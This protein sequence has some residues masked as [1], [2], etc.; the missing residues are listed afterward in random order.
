ML[1]SKVCF[2]T[3]L[4]LSGVVSG[5][6]NSGS[7]SGGTSQTLTPAVSWPQPSSIPYGTALSATQ[8]NATANVS[9]TFVY[10]PVAGTVL[11][12]GTQG[13]TVTFTPA[14]GSPMTTTTLIRVTGVVPSY[15]WNNMSIVGGGFVTGII[16]HPKQQYLRYAR[17]DIGG[18]YRWNQTAGAWVSLLDQFN[19]AQSNYIGVESIALD[20]ND[21]LR[22]Y[23]AVGM[24]TESY[25]SNGAFLLSADQ[26]ATFTTVA[27]PFKMGSNDNGRYAGER[28]AVDPNLPTTLYFG[29]R[30]N[31]LW[32]SVD[33]GLTWTQSTSFPVTAT[34]SGV[35]IVFVDF[36][37]SSGTSGSATPA[38]Y[39][40]VSDTGT[41]STGYASLYRSTDAGKTWSAVPSQPTG[42]YPS[43]GALGPDGALYLSYGNGT[44]PN[45]VTSGA[46]WQ[47]A[48]PSASTPTGAGVWTNITPGL[49]ARPA[50]SQG[51]FGAVAVDP[52]QSGVL[53][54][55]TMDDY[56]PYGDDIYRSVDYG[57]HWVSLD[58]QGATHNVSLSPWITFGATTAGTGNWPG[59]LVIDPFD[60]KHVLYGSGQTVWDSANIQVSDAGSP[61]AFS[62]AAVGLEETAVLALMSPTSGAS[63]VSGVGDIGGFVHTSLTSSPAGG[64]SQ[65]PIFG[66]TTGLDFAQSKPAS[67]VRVGTDSSNQFGSYSI[68]GGTTWKAFAANPAGTTAGQG[69]IAISADGASIVWATSDAAVAVSTDSGTTWKASTGATAKTAVFADRVNAK[70][71]YL[72]S[73]ST[74][75]LQVSADGGA[76]FT[77]G[78]TGLATGAVM[79]VSPAGEGDL[80]IAGSTGILRSTNSGTSF[81]VVNSTVQSAYAIGFGKGATG[82]YPAIYAIGTGANGY[83]F[84]RSVDTGA[85]WI[86]INDAAHQYGYVNII[87]G[88]P[89]IFGRVYLGTQ[90][91]GII[92]GDSPN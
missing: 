70:K 58:Q 27:A 36:V 61:P 32:S 66:N 47:Y 18:A 81:S 16:P 14:S 6:S 48:L 63:L 7:A 62:V 25:G 84:Y 88:D 35:G 74:G 21:P 87:L 72:Y 13:L 60:S 34:T 4:L 29:S 77:S 90:G 42:L 79:A 56:Y 92:Y 86:Q 82:G 51:G 57:K 89:R 1:V 78:A 73:S 44:G 59:T 2:C 55:S 54:A 37:P 15:T 19:R 75:A 17:T 53:M 65:P 76:S 50:N 11:Q 67:L 68:D 91:R 41:S 3:F 24:Y 10:A 28:L 12:P 52:E 23:M 85:T 22:L 5:C 43:H 49:P 64:M 38:I 9:G 45:G 71:F 33:R 8:L 30:L 46:V 80:W 20:P 69:T 39:V 26:G 31:G 83:G 40:G